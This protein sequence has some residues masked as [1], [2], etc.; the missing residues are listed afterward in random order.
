MNCVVE[1]VVGI[2]DDEGI[3][4]LVLVVVFFDQFFSYVD[5]GYCFVEVV[6]N[7]IDWGSVDDVGVLFF[8]F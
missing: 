7:W 4:L 8:V 6:W 5:W 3:V 1:I 2:V